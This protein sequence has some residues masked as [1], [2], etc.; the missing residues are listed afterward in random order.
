MS[1]NAQNILKGLDMVPFKWLVNVIL[2]INSIKSPA[3]FI[4]TLSY[5]YRGV[6][7]EKNFY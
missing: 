5:K 2:Y 6:S 4:N 3:Y 1:G 7:H